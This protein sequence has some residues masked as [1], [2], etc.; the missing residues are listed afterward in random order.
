MSEHCFFKKFF[1]ESLK[2]DIRGILKQRHKNEIEN[3]FVVNHQTLE[4]NV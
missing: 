4:R 3:S 1:A 2:L